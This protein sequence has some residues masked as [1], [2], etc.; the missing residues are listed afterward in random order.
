MSTNA[1]VACGILENYRENELKMKAIDYYLEAKQMRELAEKERIDADALY[2]A[3]EFLTEAI[4]ELTNA[5]MT[6]YKKRDEEDE[7][8]D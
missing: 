3:I 8:E 1:K 2:Y 4:R 5:I 6:E 7:D